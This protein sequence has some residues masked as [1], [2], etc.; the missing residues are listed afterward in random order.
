MGIRWGSRTFPRMVSKDREGLQDRRSG[1]TPVKSKVIDKDS[2]PS[3]GLPVE[4]K[5]I[6][7]E[8]YED[9]QRDQCICAGESE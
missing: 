4:G 6:P 2:V 3:K 7:V 9:Q 8:S 5:M 1:T